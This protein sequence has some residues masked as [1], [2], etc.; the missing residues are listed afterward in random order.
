MCAVNLVVPY[1]NILK[2]PGGGEGHVFIRK[3]C[4]VE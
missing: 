2:V 1:T 4:I 3:F